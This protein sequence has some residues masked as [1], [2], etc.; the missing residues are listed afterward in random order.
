M[1]RTVWPAIGLSWPVT[2]RED[3]QCSTYCAVRRWR[4][5]P[6]TGCGL[7][8]E[9][10]RT[11]VARSERERKLTTELGLQPSH[12]RDS[13]KPPFQVST[14]VQEPGLQRSSQINSP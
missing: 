2:G 9:R 12:T 8:G 5:T 6:R 3:R 1:R 7:L 11:G 13:T 14:K 10:H 4:G